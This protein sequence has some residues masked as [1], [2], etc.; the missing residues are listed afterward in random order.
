MKIFFFIAFI[1]LLFVMRYQGSVLSTSGSGIL[2]LELADKGEGISIM[3]KW[4]ITSYGDQSL[5]Q[6]AQTNTKWDF[7]FILSY[8]ALMIALSNWQMQR[9][10][11]L[12][13]NEMLRFNLFVMV[14]AGLLDV[15]ENFRL[16]HNFHHG[17]DISNYWGTSWL[18]TIK[19]GLVGLSVLVFVSS[20][21]KSL[22]KQ[23]ASA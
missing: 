6:I 2:S 4:A 15:V 21:V 7:A 9:E 5:L 16:L 19:F 14:V 3:N 10:K 22:F 11:W 12:P 23:K 18:A 8:V 20:W 1:G 17:N 13:L